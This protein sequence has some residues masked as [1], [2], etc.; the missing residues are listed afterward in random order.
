M[1]GSR[2]GVNGSAI[3][4]DGAPW[5]P[6]GFD[7][8][9]LGTN[10]DVNKGCGAQVDLDRYFGSLPPRSLTRFNA[11]AS[12]A[13]NIHT[14]ATDF[15]PLD[16]VFA[17][18][19]RHNQFV[20][21]VLSA[22]DGAC[23][24]GVF[25]DSNW[26]ATESPSYASWLDTAV[27]RWGHSPALAG[28]E[29]VGEPEPSMCGDAQCSWQQRSC[30]PG[31]AATLRSFF[32]TAGSRLRALDPDTPIWAGTA[33]GSQCGTRGDDF[34]LVSSSPS[35]DVLDLHDYGPPGVA[36]PGDQANGVQRR[37]AQAA[38]LG[39]PL[40]VGEMGQTAGSCEPL[41]VRAGDLAAKVTAERHAGS[42]GVLFWDYVPDPRL[43]DCT[44][45]I[46]PNDPL[47]D[48]VAAIGHQLTT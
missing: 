38:A 28:W 46:G 47:F 44:M 7:A 22:G 35:I 10:R 20:V 37:L 4:L 26:Y 5:W 17:A 43:N 11:F 16:A 23:E 31:A 48:V 27:A 2:V 25:K 15:R 34:S 8:Y 12:Q 42:A 13:Y 33:G 19:E 45:D 21:A 30:P 18:A 29:L 32:D 36:L 39:K 1:Q 40:V 3:T 24:D 6:S 9:E 14:N 41:A